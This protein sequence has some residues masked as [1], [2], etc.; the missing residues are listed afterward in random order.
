LLDAG[1]LRLTAARGPRIGR[2]D[3]LAL[4]RAQREAE[5]AFGLIV[6]A[7]ERHGLRFSLSH[8]AE[9]EWR[10][11]FSAMFAPT[12]FGVATTPWQAV[13]RAAGGGEASNLNKSLPA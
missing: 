12:G 7:G 13:Q 5:D 3:R 4:L 2:P 10:A 11:Q 1:A 8:I 6:V 9:D